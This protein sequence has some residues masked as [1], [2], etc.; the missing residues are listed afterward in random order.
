M[1]KNYILVLVRLGFIL[2]F[3]CSFAA[4]IELKIYPKSKVNFSYGAKESLN[5]VFATFDGF[6]RKHVSF[7]TGERDVPYF[8]GD[9]IFCSKDLEKAFP[10]GKDF[11][12]PVHFLRQV[13]KLKNDAV[14][15]IKKYDYKI[16][17]FVEIKMPNA[18]NK[19]LLSYLLHDGLDTS[20]DC[21]DFC[22]EVFS[23]SL[24][25]KETF[26]NWLSLPDEIG[27]ECEFFKEEL[28]EREFEPGDAI[29]LCVG[30]FDQGF[31]LRHWIIAL[32]E[33]LYI[34]KFGCGG[35]IYVHSLDF[36]MLY[37]KCSCFCRVR[38][39]LED[40]IICENI[41]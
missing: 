35:K 26:I 19:R 31:E 28:D 23:E 11:S 2:S 27:D 14:L 6:K 3:S 4:N 20:R 32:G 37:Y 18:K 29:A 10:S 8:Y 33:G 9:R 24:E 30:D 39:Q 22:L 41:I 7:R 5:A 17:D 13:K 21:R 38:K 34:S 15:V 16:M 36:A 12:F 40:C 25:S 1:K